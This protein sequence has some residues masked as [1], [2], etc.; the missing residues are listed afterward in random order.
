MTVLAKNTKKEGRATSLDEYVGVR[1]RTRRTLMGMSQE[2]LAD[3]LGITF[4]QVQKYERGVNRVGASRLY[5][6]STTLEVPVSFFFEGLVANQKLGAGK[7][8]KTRLGVAAPKAKYAAE[9]ESHD[10]E[11]LELVR[12]YKAIQ[13]PDMRKSVLDMIRSLAKKSG[14]Q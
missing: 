2:K 1:I 5:D 14:D 11:I 3:A 9:K 12:A 4:Q 10:R 8:S 6:L 13:N 7:K